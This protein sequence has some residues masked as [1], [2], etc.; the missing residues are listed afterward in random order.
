MFTR[1]LSAIAL[2]SSVWLAHADPITHQTYAFATLGTPKYSEGFE[3]YDYANPSAPKGGSITLSA[4]G[5]FDNFNRYA[6]RGLA[7]ARSESLYDSLYV[8]SEDE[9]GSYYP[10][11]AQRARYA[12]DYSWVEVDMNPQARFH[13][14]T[15]ITAADVAF[16]FNLFMTQGV[17]QF[18]VYYKGTQAT[19]TAALTVRFSFVEPDKE[20]MLG[21]LTLPVMPEKFWRNHQLSDPLSTPPL[22]SGPYRISDYRMGQY[23]VYRRQTDYWAAD[24]PVNRGRYNF[25]QIRYDYYLDDSV[26][27]EAFKAGAFDMRTEGSPK[28]WATQYDGGNIARGYIVKRD[29]LNQ[30]AQDTRWLV[31]NIQRPLFSDSRVRQAIALAFDFDWMNKALFFNSYQRPSSFFQNTEY[32]AKGEPSEEELHWLTPLKDKLPAA[33][34][35]PAYQPATTDGSGYDRTYRQQALALLQQAGWVLKDKVLVNKQTGQPFRFELLLPGAANAIYVLPFQR[36]LARLGIRME[37]RSVDSPQFNNRFRKRDF[38]M[39]PKLYPA[40]PYPSADLAISWSSAYINSSYNSPGVQDAAIDKLIDE[41]VRHQGDKPALQALG[42]ALD[43]VLTWHQ[44]AIPMWYSG[45]ERFA[46]WNKFAMPAVRPAYSLGLDSWWYDSENAARLP[47]A[48]R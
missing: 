11:I 10:L 20:K 35:G 41:I 26:A 7:A 4:L 40:M 21:I 19:A 42:P 6:L 34:F 12:S 8:S 39:I 5:T 13:D 33:V 2:L 14:G 46:Y 29:E 36:S 17:P 27:L 32:A 3:H 30:A 1:V 25:D 45:H 16:T 9:P 38:D 15:P 31:F 28:H 47:A 44:F 18:R 43:R 37:V 48:R 23:V 22:A 24:L